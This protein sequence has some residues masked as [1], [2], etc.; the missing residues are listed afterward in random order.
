MFATQSAL[1]VDDVD[2]EIVELARETVLDAKVEVGTEEE[3]LITTLL[4]GTIV[5]EVLGATLLLAELAAE[6]ISDEVSGA[7][8]LATL[9]AELNDETTDEEATAEELTML[10]VE[11]TLDTMDD[12]GAAELKLDTAEEE[13]ITEL[14]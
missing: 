9:L 4:V 5:L 10:L 11:I 13:A 1:G 7:E 14:L 3:E 6:D 12:E 2:E 8:L